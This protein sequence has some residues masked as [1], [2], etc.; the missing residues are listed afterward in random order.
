M[1]VSKELC[2]SG[3]QREPGEGLEGQPGRDGAAQA[4]LVV[5]ELIT[6]RVKM[7]IVILNPDNLL[8]I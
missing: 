3:V 2:E 1:A 8:R 4:G 5:S 7:R 6:G